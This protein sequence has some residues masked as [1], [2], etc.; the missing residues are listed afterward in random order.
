MP[1]FPTATRT[2]RR[3]KARPVGTRALGRCPQRVADLQPAK[4]DMCARTI[5]PTEGSRFAPVRSRFG[6]TRGRSRCAARG[7]PKQ[8]RCRRERAAR[9]PALPNTAALEGVDFLAG[10]R[11]DELEQL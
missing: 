6:G 4:L 5:K 10:V 9:W 7:A 2:R 11:K 1:R 8:V 3:L